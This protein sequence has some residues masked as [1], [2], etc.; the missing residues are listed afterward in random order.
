MCSLIPHG[1]NVI[2]HGYNVIPHGYNVIPHGYN[3]IPH[4]CVVIPHGCVVTVIIISLLQ[5][6]F[7]S[8]C[9]EAMTILSS[10]TVKV[11]FS[12]SSESYITYFT[13]FISMF[14]MDWI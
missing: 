2:P 3:M 4:G 12:L 8:F 14:H 10:Q 13:L 9:H 11:K 7:P 6:S 5:S 1:Y